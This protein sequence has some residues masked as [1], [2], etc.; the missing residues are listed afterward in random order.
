MCSPRTIEWI[1]RRPLTPTT[2]PRPAACWSPGTSSTTSSPSTGRKAPCQDSMLRYLPDRASIWHNLIFVLLLLVI[3]PFLIYSLLFLF[4]YLFSFNFS[5]V[6]T[7]YI[8]LGCVLL[9]FLFYHHHHPFLLFYLGYVIYLVKLTRYFT[10]H[11][12]VSLPFCIFTCMPK[13]SIIH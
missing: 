8:V 1:Y 12:I 10:D 11:I 5:L 9:L 7:Y 13:V 6:V 2:T 4:I 3:F